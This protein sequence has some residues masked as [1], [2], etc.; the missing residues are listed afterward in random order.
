MAD[1]QDTTSAT[2]VSESQEWLDVRLQNVPKETL[3]SN[4]QPESILR[5]ATLPP[6]KKV[7][8]RTARLDIRPSGVDPIHSSVKTVLLAMAEQGLL[9]D[10]CQVLQNQPSNAPCMFD[11]T[12]P[13]HNKLHEARVAGI[14][15]NGTRC[16]F[17][18][19]A[20]DYDPD[21]PSRIK[22]MIEK[23]QPEWPLEEYEK[24]FSKFGVTK[25]VL[26]RF[27]WKAPNGTEFN[28][29]DNTIT[30]TLDSNGTPIRDETGKVITWICV[31][32]QLF[33][34][35]FPCGRR[36][37]HD[38]AAY[39][40]VRAAPTNQPGPSKPPPEQAAE[41]YE[42]VLP[43]LGER[44]GS[45]LQDVE[46]VPFD[47]TA[48][49]CTYVDE[50]RTTRL[51]INVSPQHVKHVIGKKG[52]KIKEIKEANPSAKIVVETRDVNPPHILFTG[53]KL[54]VCKALNWVIMD[55][56]SAL[57]RAEG[58]SVDKSPET[59]LDRKQQAD[60][61][62]LR[63]TRSPIETRSTRKGKQQ[64]QGVASSK[65]NPLLREKEFRDLKFKMEMDKLKAQGKTIVNSV[66]DGGQDI[67]STHEVVGRHESRGQSDLVPPGTE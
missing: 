8:F 52:K 65:Q 66:E 17:N 30:L 9:S 55:I 28:L 53:P 58:E 46:L 63:D 18:P 44:N 43:D 40:R 64:N 22:I 16:E 15:I 45:W 3:D 39:E 49:P 59:T 67:I 20:K 54:A 1:A 6:E 11:V 62:G 50:R 10:D 34:V 7:P 57:E 60:V 41:S 31:N 48:E 56:E 27:K 2:P 26:G 38:L 19:L 5:D 36:T 35:T 21:F 12:F 42:R 51:R 4:Q 13:T 29:L 33:P 32:D 23:V 37:N 24:V 61:N 25:A 14:V 47:E